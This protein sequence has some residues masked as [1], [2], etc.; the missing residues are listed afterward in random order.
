MAWRNITVEPIGG[1]LTVLAGVL[2]LP[3][4]VH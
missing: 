1:G 2:A 4:F 3:L